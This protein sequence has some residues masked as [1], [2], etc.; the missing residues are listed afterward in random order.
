MHFLMLIGQEIP[1]IA[2]PQLVIA[3]FLVFLWFLGEAKKKKKKTHVAHS[4]TEA[5]YRAL[6]DTTSELF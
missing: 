5:E 1:L 3:F 2:S 6:A 4:S